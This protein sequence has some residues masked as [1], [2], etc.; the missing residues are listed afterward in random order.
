[1]RAVSC[2]PWASAR[3]ALSVSIAA[4]SVLVA[5]T[6]C[7]AGEDPNRSKPARP[8]QTDTEGNSSPG[9]ASEWK[10]LSPPEHLVGYPAN[11]QPEV[12]KGPAASLPKLDARRCPGQVQGL[13]QAAAGLRS[14]KLKGTG[15]VYVS[16][17]RA[18]LRAGVY[19]YSQVRGL[20]EWVR[21]AT[22]SAGCLAGAQTYTVSGAGMPFF[23]AQMPQANRDSSLILRALPAPGLEAVVIC[24]STIDDSLCRGGMVE[25]VR[26][27]G[28]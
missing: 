12:V 27:L 8:P 13:R 16:G 1:M 23:A 10:P 26:S 24:T 3:C 9:R 22:Q 21:A 11:G 2:I 5:V 19:Q 25:L 17:E 4:L 15:R 7:S 14:A 20:Q 28:F 6:S 18:V